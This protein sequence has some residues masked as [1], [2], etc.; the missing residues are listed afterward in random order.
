MNVEN[1][2]LLELLALEQQLRDNI[3]T[4]EGRISV[5][6]AEL[7]EEVSE[8]AAYEQALKTTIDVAEEVTE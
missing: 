1:L 3:A 4:L 2:G 8:L 7:R 6:T 5:R